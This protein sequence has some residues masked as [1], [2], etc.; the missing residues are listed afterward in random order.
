M[1]RKIHRGGV[2]PDPLRG[3]F[4]VEQGG[5]QR[6]VEYEPDSELRDVEKVPLLEE[7]GVEGFLR[8]E[9]L[10]Y[11]PD[12]WYVPGRVKVGYEISLT[13]YF[14]QPQPLRAPEEIWADIRALERESEGLL[15]EIMGGE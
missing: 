2:A 8:R 4:A 10:P 12:A 15:G 9:V 1:I 3:L 13:R 14:Y 7:G 5:E 11:E 6:V